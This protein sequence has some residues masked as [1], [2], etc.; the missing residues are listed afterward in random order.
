M[1]QAMN[2]YAICWH[3]KGCRSRFLRLGATRPYWGCVGWQGRQIYRCGQAACQKN[4][5]FGK[6]LFINKT[7][8]EKKRPRYKLY[9]PFGFCK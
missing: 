8:I 9:R 5:F 3:E 6:C 1:A 2:M 4:G 7:G